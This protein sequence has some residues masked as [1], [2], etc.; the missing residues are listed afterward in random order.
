ML[1]HNILK[2]Y[3]DV[4]VKLHVLLTLV[5]DVYYDTHFLKN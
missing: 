2:M 4:E 5:L 3:V 1:K